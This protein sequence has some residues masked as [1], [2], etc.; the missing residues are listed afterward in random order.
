MKQTLL[1]F[2]TLEKRN[3]V[4]DE[5]V[6]KSR[7]DNTFVK[8]SDVAVET[9]DCLYIFKVVP[10]IFPIQEFAGFD[11]VEAPEILRDLENYVFELKEFLKEPIQMDPEDT[12]STDSDRN[13][14]DNKNDGEDDKSSD[15]EE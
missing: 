8:W 9:K 11:E 4:R 7:K 13:D 15:D 10:V 2:T 1:A 3:Q 6:A 14:E 12:E 5:L